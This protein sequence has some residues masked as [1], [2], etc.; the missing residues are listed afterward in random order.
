VRTRHVAIIGAG[1]AGLAAAVDLARQGVAVTLFERQ[2]SPGGKI[3]QD[4]VG[5]VAIDAG[6]TVLTMRWVFESLFADAGVSLATH[7]TLHPLDVLARHAWSATERLDLFADVGHSEQAIGSF[8]GAA[9]ARGYRAFVARATRVYDALEASFIRA[10]RPS[11]LSVVGGAGLRGLRG[12]LAGAP[13][14][15]LWQALGEH[16]DDPRLRQLFAR[17]ATYSGSSPFHCPATLMLIAHVEQQGVW[18]ID[19]GM[20]RLAPALATLAARHGAVLRYA[21]RVSEIVLDGGGASGVRLTTGEVVAADAVVSNAD[22]AALTEGWFGPRAI[23]A[24]PQPE[25]GERSLSALTWSLSA[26]TAGFPLQRHNVFFSRDYTAEFAA[27]FRDGRLPAQPT[28]YV[29]AQDRGAPGQA[30]PNG[31]PERLLVLVNAPAVGDRRA[32]TAKEIEQCEAAAFGRLE[33]C[34]LTVLRHAT[35]TTPTDF[36]ALFPATGGALYGQAVHG[37]LAAFRRPGSRSAIPRLYLAGGSVHPG[38][39]VP[40]AVLSGRLAA[41]AVLR[42]LTSD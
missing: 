31:T 14:A 11:A 1:A 36:A 23:A 39:G 19:G 13:F 26:L 29:C 17:Y 42:D 12:L 27:V 32:F 40:M 21:T 6:P 20:I 33:Q 24:V 25:I 30:S 4:R 2:A 38:P 15:T 7:L 9:A 28:V 35:M 5:N 3:R 16:F 34:G 10:E 37:T 41:K 22:V 18:A 8:A